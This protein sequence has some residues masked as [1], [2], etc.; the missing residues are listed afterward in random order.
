M[1]C[2]I[3]DLWIL[4]GLYPDENWE[5]SEFYANECEHCDPTYS[6][7]YNLEYYEKNKEDINKVGLVQY[8][9]N[10]L[11]SFG[12]EWNWAFVSSHLPF[13]LIKE[14]DLSLFGNWDWRW[15]SLNPTITYKDV[16]EFKYEDWDFRALSRNSFC[17]IRKERKEKK[18]IGVIQNSFIKWWYTPNECGEAPVALAHFNE[19]ENA[20]KNKNKNKN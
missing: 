14:N 5:K 4:Y 7:N 11:G 20:L 6:E 18:A 15:I 8:L 17:K 12:T 9:E 19:F 16:I 2:E 3:N 13:W 1:N 10:N